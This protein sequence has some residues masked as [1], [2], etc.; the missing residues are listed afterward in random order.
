VSRP[1]PPALAHLRYQERRARLR[2]FDL[3]ARFAEIYRTNLW[4]A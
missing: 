4:G 3:F 1:R 2:D